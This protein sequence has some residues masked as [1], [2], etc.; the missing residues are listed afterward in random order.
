M[1]ENIAKSTDIC[2]NSSKESNLTNVYINKMEKI[3]PYKDKKLK[4]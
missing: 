3:N 2:F 1:N 4:A